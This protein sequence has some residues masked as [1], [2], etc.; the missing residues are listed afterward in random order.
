MYHFLSGYTAKVAGTEKGLGSEPEAT[1]STC[2]GAPF[3]PR[4]PSVYAKMLGE[5]ISQHNAR[6]WLVNT[7]W[8]SGAYGVGHRM[9]I[10]HTRSLLKAAL[11]GA[12]GQVNMREDQSFGLKV[13]EKCPNV[14]DEIMTPRETWVDKGAYDETARGLVGRFHENF[15]QFKPYVS[16][17]VADAAPHES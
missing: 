7:G 13:P 11:T 14:P 4:H 2:F 9:P 5:R 3:M 1:F 10:N 15:T 17:D 16:A 6:C 8:T 12:L